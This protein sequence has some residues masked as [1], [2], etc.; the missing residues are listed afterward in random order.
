V[1]ASR[2]LGIRRI[3][4]AGLGWGFGW[5]F[6]WGLGWG[7]GGVLAFGIDAP[8]RVEEYVDLLDLGLILV[9]SGLLLFAA[10]AYLNRPRRRT[11]RRSSWDDRTD[12]W[13]E[14]DMHR[15]GYAGETRQLPTV[16]ENRRR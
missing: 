16:R 15:P 7:L 13:Y 10:E 8:S 9:W 3:V 14:Q 5:G 4:L 2:G 1:A 11:P 12:Q 6:G